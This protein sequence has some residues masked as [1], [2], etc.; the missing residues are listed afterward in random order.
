MN[1]ITHIT[2][3]KKSYKEAANEQKLENRLKLKLKKIMDNIFKHFK[4][5]NMLPKY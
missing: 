3:I 2:R 5:L 1:Q 4:S